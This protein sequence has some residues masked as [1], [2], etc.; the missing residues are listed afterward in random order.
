M[1]V[2]V[3]RSDRGGRML[4]CSCSSTRTR[5]CG[6]MPA[7]Y[8]TNRATRCSSPRR[9]WTDVLPV[10][11]RRSWPGTASS[12]AA[13]T[14]RAT[15]ASPAARRLAR[16]IAR[17][18]CPAGKGESAV[19]AQPDPGRAGEAR[20]DGRAVHRLRDP[21]RCGHRSSTPPRALSQSAPRHSVPHHRL[22]LSLG[23]LRI[24]PRPGPVG[25]TP[26]RSARATSAAARA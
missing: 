22:A 13:S 5:C 24:Q 17:L 25:G 2:L 9:R 7:G 20:R 15:G 12:P 16:G 19:G 21:A 3:F 4:S 10:T 1:V 14:T 23:R 6:G 18:G 26:R 8:G 11:P